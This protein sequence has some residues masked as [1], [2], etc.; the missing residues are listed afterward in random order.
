MLPWQMLRASHRLRT[1]MQPARSALRT[2]PQTCRRRMKHPARHQGGG[3]ARDNLACAMQSVVVA[4]PICNQGHALHSGGAPSAGVRAR[5]SCKADCC[6]RCASTR[7][8]TVLAC[9]KSCNVATEKVVTARSWRA[10]RAYEPMVGASR[11]GI[12]PHV[13]TC[14]AATR[15]MRPA[16]CYV[17]AA[18]TV[19]RRHLGH[20]MASRAALTPCGESRPSPWKRARCVHLQPGSPRTL[21]Y[22]VRCSYNG[23]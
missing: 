13:S 17:P 2:S 1:L 9:T 4:M 22:P 7:R 3:L 23:R 21:G 12:V 16:A 19:G 10:V 14:H 11:V 8:A 5:T 6:W 18:P 20:W 15:A